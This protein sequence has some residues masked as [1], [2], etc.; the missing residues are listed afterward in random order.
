MA[1]QA[2][3]DTIVQIRASSFSAKQFTK[4]KRLLPACCMP[5]GGAQGGLVSAPATVPGRS[6]SLPA[7]LHSSPS[8]SQVLSASH[9]FMQLQP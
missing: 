9:S 4:R 8:P 3:G 6:R 5:K 1:K 7:Q 2:R